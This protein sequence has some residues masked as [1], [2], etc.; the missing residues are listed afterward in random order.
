VTWRPLCTKQARG[1]AKKLAAP[2]VDLEQ[3][4]IDRTA[5][6]WTRRGSARRRFCRVRR[7]RRLYRMRRDARRHP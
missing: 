2:D 1:D 7:E 4:R 3:T 5:G 6:E